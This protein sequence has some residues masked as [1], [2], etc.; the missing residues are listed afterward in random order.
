MKNL[1]RSTA[2]ISAGILIMLFIEGM[3]TFGAAFCF[4]KYNVFGWIIQGI[5]LL[6]TIS[7]SAYISIQENDKK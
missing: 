2:S 5:I 6:F 3:L 4:E 7:F 1:L